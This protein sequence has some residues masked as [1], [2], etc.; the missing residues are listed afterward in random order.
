MGLPAVHHNRT[1]EEVLERVDSSPE[2]QK[3]TGVS[4]YAVIRPADELNLSDFSFRGFLSL[5]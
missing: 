4:R 5:L 3:Q 2:L 1:A